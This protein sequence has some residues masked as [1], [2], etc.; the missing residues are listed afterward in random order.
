MTHGHQAAFWVSLRV[1]HGWNEKRALKRNASSA[2]W[3]ELQVNGESPQS[4]DRSRTGTALTWLTSDILQT[5]LMCEWVRDTSL[6]RHAAAQLYTP[7]NIMK[8]NACIFLEV[9]FITLLHSGTLT[10]TFWAVQVNLPLN[11]SILRRNPTPQNDWKGKWNQIS[12]FYERKCFSPQNK[13]FFRLDKHY[14]RA[15]EWKTFCCSIF[16]K[17]DKSQE[18]FGIRRLFTFMVCNFSGIQLISSRSDKMIM[19]NCPIRHHCPRAKKT[20]GWHHGY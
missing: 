5:G 3:T 17:V 4:A 10:F 15:T 11:M 16:P 1:F 13:H 19:Q 20:G 2:V 9:I 6:Y 12:V 8:G 18:Y 14:F 7:H